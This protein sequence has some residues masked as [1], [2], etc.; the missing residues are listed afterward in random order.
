MNYYVYKYYCDS[1]LLYVGKTYNVYRRFRQHL[2]NEKESE[3]MQTVN[4]IEVAECNSRVDMALYEVYYIN[5][6][7]PTINKKDTY[8]TSPSVELNPELSFIRYDIPSFE[9][10][11]Q[12]INKKINPYIIKELVTIER[13]TVY[14]CLEGLL[15]AN[16]DSGF[17]ADCWEDV[18]T[19]FEN[20]SDPEL[21]KK[22]K[23]IKRAYRKYIEETE[24]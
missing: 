20:A 1:E 19:Y 2:Q 12:F 9:E 21:E 8:E 5:K 15:I 17:V 4:F 22:L 18:K 13:D 11:Y 16:E 10:A 7:F 3:W 14:I 23:K 24:D 6:C